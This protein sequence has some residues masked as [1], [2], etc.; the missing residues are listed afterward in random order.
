[1]YLPVYNGKEISIVAEVRKKV[2]GIDISSHQTQSYRSRPAIDYT[3][4][5]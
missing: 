1:M 5:L 4:T 2:V 3:C